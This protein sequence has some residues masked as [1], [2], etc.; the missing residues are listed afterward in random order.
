[1]SGQ[2]F[3]AAFR[4][5]LVLKEAC[6][7][8]KCK[9]TTRPTTENAP[10]GTNARIVGE[11]STSL[12]AINRVSSERTQGIKRFR[13][14]TRSGNELPI[15]GADAV[16]AP[17]GPYDVIVQRG[18]EGEVILDSGAKAR[19]VGTK[20]SAS[21]TAGSLLAGTGGA[22]AKRL[23]KGD[24]SNSDAGVPLDQLLTKYSNAPDTYS[25][26]TA[27]RKQAKNM[28]PDERA[29]VEKAIA[30]YSNALNKSKPV[31]KMNKAR[32]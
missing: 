4:L 30:Q 28:D 24:K 17:A 5:L 13:V 22:L 31:R 8:P 18:P 2:V 26:I 11:F 29:T 27:F 23:P 6:G 3:P 21:Q 14:D 1:M 15:V 25:K 7:C 19:P 16:D 12:E 9:P 20:S 32:Q 10:S